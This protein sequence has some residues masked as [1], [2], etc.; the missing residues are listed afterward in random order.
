MMTAPAP[1]RRRD[2]RSPRSPSS[3]WRLRQQEDRRPSAPTRASTS[4]SGPMPTR[5]RSRAS[6]TRSDVEDREYLQ[7]LP[8][9]H[10]G[11]RRRDV[12]RRLAA[13]AERERQHAAGGRRLRD[14]RHARQ[15][16]TRP[17]ALAER[18][19]RSPTSRRAAWRPR[20]ADPAGVRARPAAGSIQGSLLLFKLK[21]TSLANRPLEL[22][23][24]Q[25][26]GPRARHRRA[27]RL[28]ARPA[29]PGPCCSAVCEHAARRG[30][31][32]VAARALPDE[33]HGDGDRA[34]A[35]AG[36][37]RDEPGV[38]V[39]RVL[40]WR[41]AGAP[42]SAGPS[43]LTVLRELGG[44]G[45]AGDLDARR[46]R[47]RPRCRTS[48]PRASSARP[49]APRAAASRV[50]SRGRW[51]AQQRRVERG[52]RRSRSSP[53]TTAICSG[54]GQH[55]ALA[56]RR[57]ADGEVVADLVAGRD[58]ALGRRPGSRAPR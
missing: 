56:D 50:T 6:S 27:R 21:I 5:S 33:Q 58:R 16:R 54:G 40:V 13:G 18:P 41:R 45:L 2:R 24:T 39:G 43:S 8:A 4:T 14:P 53:P 25:P 55:L 37:K 49:S 46:S 51:P 42:S 3:R 31:G 48:R 22:H 17:I 15:S 44:A 34:A 35:R 47:R 10:A 52:G 38:G 57:R 12:V 19:T 26:D 9:G 11:R 28:A 32:D 30:R 36:A 29:A 7:G 23:I 20:P 1:H